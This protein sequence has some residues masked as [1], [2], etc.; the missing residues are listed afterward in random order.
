MAQRLKRSFYRFGLSAAIVL[1]AMLLLLFSHFSN[2]TFH[3][4]TA[5]LQQSFSKKEQQLYRFTTQAM[6]VFTLKGED[7]MAERYT[8]ASPFYLHVYRNDS[9]VFWNTN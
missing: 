4:H 7:A 9:L 1:G 2:I 8:T 3:D 6:K 5:E